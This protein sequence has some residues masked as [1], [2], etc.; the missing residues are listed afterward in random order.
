MTNADTVVTNKGYHALWLGSPVPLKL[1]TL[2]RNYRR[3]LLP[4]AEVRSSV[5]EAAETRTLSGQRLARRT[6]GRSN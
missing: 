2:R 1:E 3:E 4:N 6:R 5:E